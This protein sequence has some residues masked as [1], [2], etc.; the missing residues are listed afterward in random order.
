MTV[1]KSISFTDTHDAWIKA[2]LASGQYASESELI[3]ELIRERQQREQELEAIRAELIAA[4]A[5]G[6]SDRTPAQILADFK[7]KRK[8]DDAL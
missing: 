1:R 8:N 3:R 2:Q 5:S 6:L 7:A 4:E